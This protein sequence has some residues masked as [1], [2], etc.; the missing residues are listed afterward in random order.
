MNYKYSIN[1]KNVDHDDDNDNNNGNGSNNSDNAH[2]NWV[3]IKKMKA[4][5][6]TS[7]QYNRHKSKLVF[8]GILGS[9]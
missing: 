6:R 1:E 8:K 3:G 7:L 9:F 4:L 5:I 2:N